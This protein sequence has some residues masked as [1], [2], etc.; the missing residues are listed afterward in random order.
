MI[1]Y[2]QE[3]RRPKSTFFLC[4]LS[5]TTVTIRT[6]MSLYRSRSGEL[7]SFCSSYFASAKL[8][9]TL[10]FQSP[11]FGTRSRS[12]ISGVPSRT[13]V[14][15]LNRGSPATG[16]ILPVTS[17]SGTTVRAN[18]SLDNPSLNAYVT[19]PGPSEMLGHR[20]PMLSLTPSPRKGPH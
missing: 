19:G 16:R 17:Y 15:L 7:P 10:W 9:N 18:K 8:L 2:T 3:E 13:H 4:F 1:I 5:S 14:I 6:Q 20:D 12:E 11:K